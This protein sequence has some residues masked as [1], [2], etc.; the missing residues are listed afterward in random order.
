[1]KHKIPEGYRLQYIFPGEFSGFKSNFYY[2]E[3]NACVF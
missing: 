1:M 3:E 2:L